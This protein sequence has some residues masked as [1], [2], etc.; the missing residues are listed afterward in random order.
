MAGIPI[1]SDFDVA[2]AEPIDSKLKS[3]STFA[4]LANTPFPY[5]GMQRLVEDE[6]IIYYLKTDLTTWENTINSSVIGEPTGAD[7]VKNMVSLTQSEYDVGTPVLTT[8]YI[9]TDA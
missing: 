8:L 4:D 7:S 2:I 6:N 3:V 5:E 1:S 9:I